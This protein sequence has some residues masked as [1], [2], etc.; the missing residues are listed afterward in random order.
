MLQWPATPSYDNNKS[1]KSV[2]IRSQIHWVALEEANLK[3]IKCKKNS[4]PWS[5]KIQNFAEIYSTD[6]KYTERLRMDEYVL[7]LL[8]AMSYVYK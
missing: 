6:I 4:L 1:F 7:E 3:K 5:N 2:S 8:L